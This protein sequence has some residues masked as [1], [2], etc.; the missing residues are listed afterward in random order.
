MKTT[1]LYFAEK[2]SFLAA[3]ILLFSNFTFGE[4]KVLQEKSFQTSEG[5][6]LK[7]DVSPGDVYI[8]TWDKKEVYVKITGNRKAEEKI[9]FSFE[10][11]D[12]NVEI[13][14]KK[15]SFNFF[16]W[17]NI[18]VKYEIKVPKH[19]YPYVRTSGGDVYLTDLQGNAYLRTSGGNITL[20][21]LN[22]ELNGETSGG[23]INIGLIK[24]NTKISTSGEILRQ[25]GLKEI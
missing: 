2:L 6:Q 8:S 5:K 3:A 15:S 12:G 17:G 20:D 18:S 16:S 22:G 7:V 10:N 24:G 13:Y 11:K 21:R 1:L 19:F 14:A 23:N 4:M 9:K 25:N